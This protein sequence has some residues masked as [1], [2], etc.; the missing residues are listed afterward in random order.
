MP[1][2]WIIAGRPDAAA[3]ALQLLLDRLPIRQR[4]IPMARVNGREQAS[5][6]LL[7][8]QLRHGFPVQPGRR[9][10]V[11]IFL[12]GRARDPH[13]ARHRCIAQ[14]QPLFEPKHFLDPPH[15]HLRSW[16][17]PAP[18]K[19]A[20]VAA[21][22]CRSAARPEPIR[23]A[24]NAEIRCRIGAK[25]G[26]AFR[27]NHLPLSTEIRCRF[28]P[29]FAGQSSEQ[30]QV[31]VLLPAHDGECRPLRRKRPRGTSSRSCRRSGVCRA[32]W[33]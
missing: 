27:R 25:S 19:G 5:V 17:L 31:I 26:A 15:R 8:A 29:I 23:G 10:A 20:T 16:H 32:L 28:A 2:P 30:E 1:S 3:S 22:T 33:G 12:H 11:E 9:G 24:E 4:T 21:I 13:A 18:P 14:P 7:L 6:E